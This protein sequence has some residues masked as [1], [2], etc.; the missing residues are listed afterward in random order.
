MRTIFAPPPLHLLKLLLREAS[1]LILKH[2]ME[3]NKLPLF[4]AVAE[5]VGYSDDNQI[6]SLF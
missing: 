3:R 4:L 2:E 1:E 6:R 5:L